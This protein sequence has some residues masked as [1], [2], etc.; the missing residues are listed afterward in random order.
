M[1][2]CYKEQKPGHISYFK[3]N[4]FLIALFIFLSQLILSAII[5][6]IWKLYRIQ[7]KKNVFYI[8][9]FCLMLKFT[10]S[11]CRERGDWWLFW[12]DSFAPDEFRKSGIKFYSVTTNATICRAKTGHGVTASVST[13]KCTTCDTL[14]SGCFLPRGRP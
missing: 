8:V 5:L 12:R 10:R 4:P 3:L 13:L 6:I 7:S 14:R 9:F 1:N 2:Y 11:L